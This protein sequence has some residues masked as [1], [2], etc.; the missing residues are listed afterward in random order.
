LIAQIVQPR[1]EE[2]FELAQAEVR[3]AGVW[4]LLTSGMVLTGGAS[5][6]EGAAELAEEVF[7]LPVKVGY[8]TGLSGLM[9]NA[10]SPVY[11][12]SVGLVLY[13]M[14]GGAAAETIRGDESKVFK[15]ILS[16]MRGWFEDFF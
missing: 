7:D 5:Q 13:G 9:E 4:D 10:R 6:I 16:R 3:K 15:K 11:A 14:S 12:T 2:L 1:M 8:P